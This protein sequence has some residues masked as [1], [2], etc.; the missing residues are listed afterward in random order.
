MK[1]TRFAWLMG[2]LCGSVAG[3]V[4]SQQIDVTLPTSGEEVSETATTKPDEELS[5][6][7]RSNP[8][9]GYQW[10]LTMQQS[11]AV[12]AIKN[13]HY[14]RSEPAMVGSG[15]FDIWTFKALRAG[16]AHLL[17]EYLRSWE[18]GSTRQRVNIEVRVTDDTL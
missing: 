5:I 14:V 2:I 18:P 11:D 16:T 4:A 7:L 17:F 1:R 13:K 12:L 10:R 3:C 9:T 6:K 15:G 8:T